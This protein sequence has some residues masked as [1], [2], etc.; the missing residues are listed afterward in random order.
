VLVYMFSGAF[1]KK[2]ATC[3]IAVAGLIG[4]PVLAADL[5]TKGAP[6]PHPRRSLA[7]QDF[8]SGLTRAGRSAIRSRK[9]PQVF[10]SAN[11]K[12][13]RCFPRAPTN[14]VSQAEACSGTI[15]NSTVSLLV[16]KGISTTSISATSIL[17]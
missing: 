1:M 7:G 8:I 13:L 3:V 6:P 10:F 9:S 16:L 15:G 14:R 12:G 5:A 11:L 17:R 4:T 2:L